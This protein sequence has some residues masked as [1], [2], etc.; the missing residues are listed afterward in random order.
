M[1]DQRERMAAAYLSARY[2]GT[3][4]GFDV[5]GDAGVRVIHVKRTLEGTSRIGNVVTPIDLSTSENNYLP[6]ISALV[7]WRDDLQ[8]HF[9]AG[10]TLTRPEFQRLNPALSLIPPTVNAPGTG[11][12]G[13]AGLAPTKSTNLDATLE[14]YFAGN[15]YAQLALFHRDFTGYLQD[16]TQDEIINGERYRVT[17]PQNSGQGTLKGFEFGTQKFF[18]FLPGVWSGFGAQYNFTW[19]K[20]ENET[21][22]DVN[23]DVLTKTRLV[24][25]ARKSHNVALLYEAH[26]LTGRLAAT[27]RGDYVEQVAEPRFLQDRIVKASTYVDLS[28]SYELTRN[29]S[30]QFDAINLTKEKYESYVGDTARPRDIRYTPTTYGVGLRFKL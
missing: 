5:S 11:S 14:Y 18:D 15:G 27:R 2:Q 29:I 28:L 17:R 1:F 23:S 30:V 16:Y 21:R 4:G 19:I 8:S 24:N 12:A 13:N 26:G 3:L 25:V 20:D 10:K 7:G 22:L 6:S 9:S